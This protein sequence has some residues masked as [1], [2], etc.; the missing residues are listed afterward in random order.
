MTSRLT[1]R[2]LLGTGMALGAAGLLPVRV[3][4]DSG[5]VVFSTFTGSWEEAHRD[6]LVPAFKKT[7]GA[8]VV[9]DPL[10]ALD[11]IAKVRA[12]RNNPPF[13]LILMDPGPALVAIGDD[14]VQ[15][16]DKTQS[17]H[18]GDLLPA[19]QDERGP[20]IFF[21]VVG[22]AYNPDKVK[23][24]PKSWMDLWKPEYKGRVGLTNLGSTL[25]TAFM[26]ELARLQGGSET[27]IEP[28]F[29]AIKELLPSVAGIAPNPGALATL[30]QQ[31]QI[32]IGPA[33]FNNV[34]LLRARGVPIAFAKP[35]SGTIA[36]STS[37]HIVKHAANPELAWKL[38]ETAMSPEVQG[39][40]ADQP[41][42]VIPTNT[43][44]AMTGDLASF[45]A[46]DQ[47][48]M[49]QSFVFHDWAKI[50]QNRAAWIER[51]NKEVKV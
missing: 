19:A 5:R 25:G 31:G 9:L 10:L 46:K 41:Y 43:K 17:R 51:F 18:F 6:V 8:D 3:F 2:R 35:E 34:Q 13:D 30:Y 44:V 39:K 21:Q 11:Q 50:N 37:I 42:T 28:A 38:I 14:L 36:F 26:V 22:M 4:A 16:F 15:T 23:T 20:G 29:K 1:R 27:D 24:P 45:I 40:L 12:A 47:A 48:E 7:Y 49:K 32:D 33:N